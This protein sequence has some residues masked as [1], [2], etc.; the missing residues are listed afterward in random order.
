MAEDKLL[1]NEILLYL[2]NTTKNNESLEGPFDL[3]K[4]WERLG[5]IRRYFSS[6]NNVYTS[7][8]TK[9]ILIKFR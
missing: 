7:S 3:I 9:E 8:L 2:K 4:V 5:W 6:L 1:S